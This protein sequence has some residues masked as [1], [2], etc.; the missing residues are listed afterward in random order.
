MRMSASIA[1]FPMPAAAAMPRLAVVIPNF[2]YAEFVG[3]AI[4][5]ALGIDWPHVRVIVVDDGSTDASRDVIARYEGRITTVL[6]ENAG[7]FEAYNAGF[8]LVTEEVVIFLDSDD[9]LDPS[10]MKEIAAVWRPGIS[11]VQYRMRTVDACGR[12]LG[13][14]IPQFHHVPSPEDIRH[15]AATTTA[16]PTPPGSGNAYSREYLAKIFPLDDSCGR[17]GDACCLAA[18]PFLGDVVT[19]P[20]ALGSYRIH[21]RNDGAASRL[22]VAQFQLHVVRALQRHV[23][24]QR[25]ARRAGIDIEDRA[26]NGSL[27]YLP[28]RLASLRLAPMTHPIVGDSAFA[29]L[30]DVMRALPKAQGMSS[31]SKLT[32]AVW[33]ALVVVLPAN[34]GSRL[35]LWRFVPA[36]RPQSLRLALLKFGVFR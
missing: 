29:V 12:P 10:V 31:R 14:V 9:L 5:S 19:I 21:G 25:I 18:A 3:Q 16:Y 36:A 11:K 22:D 6:Q 24:A 30:T 26:I 4:D 28:Y 8:R 13:N 20:S 1:R 35:I 15:W 7:Q 17:P 34:A 2:N 32:I 23:Y 33:A 27:S